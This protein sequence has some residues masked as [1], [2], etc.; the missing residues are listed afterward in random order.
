MVRLSLALL[1]ALALC[2]SPAVADGAVRK[3]IWGPTELPDGRSAFPVY[4]DLGVDVLQIQLGWD[5]VAPDRPAD[6][7]DPLDPAY[8]WP[9]SLDRAVAGGRRS[10]V[11]IALMVRGAPRWANGGHS[12]EWAPT[13][14]HYARFLTA[15]ARRYP[16]VRRWMIWGEPN[17]AGVFKPLPPNGR[18]GPRTY[19]RLLDAAYGA[20][21]RANRRNTV[22][23]GM[24]FSFGEVQPARWLRLMRLPNGRPPRLDEYGHNPFSRTRP[25]IRLGAFERY[26]DA[27]DISEMDRFARELHRAY[28]V[29]P[30]FR[31]HGPPLWISEFTVS[32]DR[33]NRAFDFAVNRRQ[34]ADWLRRAFSIARKV[35]ASGFG[36]FGLLDEPAGTPRGLTTGLMTGDARPKPAY[37]A[38]RRLP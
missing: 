27:R 14:R 11:D 35:G 32:S 20:L 29:Q 22:V 26:P 3:A 24:T 7:T 12:S 28:R 23:G 36:W 8:R 1:V 30:R 15:A 2:M 6:P 34:Q 21:K 13:P 33:P 18:R 25:D 16:S 37:R 10:G 17:R 19:A 4:R 31:R 38:Y 5:G 9:A